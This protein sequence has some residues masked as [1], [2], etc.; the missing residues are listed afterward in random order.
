[1]KNIESIIEYWIS[2][3]KNDIMVMESL[4]KEKHYPYALFIGHLAIEK[5]LKGY[6]VF[7]NKKHPPFIHDLVRLSTEAGLDLSDKKKKLLDAISQFNIEA[8]YPDIKLSFYKKA[9]KIFTEKYIKEI[10]GFY[11]WLKEKIQL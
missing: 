6:Y 11:K 5:L 10:K 4:F 2:L 1:M 7:K 3:A 9:N 8:R